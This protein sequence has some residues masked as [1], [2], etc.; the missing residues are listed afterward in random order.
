MKKAA[1][2]ETRE[3]TIEEIAKKYFYAVRERG[4]LDERGN[5]SED[6]IE[7]SV[8]SLQAAL[9]AAYEAGRQSR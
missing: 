8:W 7:T 9:E 5:D 6:F 4:D 2:A 1:E 3:Q